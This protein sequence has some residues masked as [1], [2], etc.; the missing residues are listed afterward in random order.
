MFYIKW[1][2]R[3]GFVANFTDKTFL[4]TKPTTHNMFFTE[5]NDRLQMLR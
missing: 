4:A 1:K 2:Q 3:F 5:I